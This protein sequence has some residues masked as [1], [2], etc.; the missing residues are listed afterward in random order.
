MQVVEQ[1]SAGHIKDYMESGGILLSITYRST[2]KE[3]HWKWL[4][5][6]FNKTLFVSHF[7]PLVQTLLIQTLT[8]SNL[9]STPLGLEN[10]WNT[11]K[12]WPQKGVSFILGAPFMITK[13]GLP[14]DRP[15]CLLVGICNLSNSPLLFFLMLCL[16]VMFCIRLN[17]TECHRGHGFLMCRVQ[18]CTPDCFIPFYKFLFHFAFSDINVWDFYCIPYCSQFHLLDIHQCV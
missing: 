1:N 15:Y 5:L 6:S 4:L 3:L 8:N 9:L 11:W 2:S 14:G 17:F 13:H 7:G 10:V 18:V 12:Y 16:Q